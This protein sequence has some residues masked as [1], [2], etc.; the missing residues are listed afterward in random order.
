MTKA[1]LKKIMKKYNIIECE[2]EDVIF[3]VENL[4]QF[5]ATETEKNE[6][7]AINSIAMLKDAAYEVWNLLEYIDD[8]MEE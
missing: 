6:P 5:K 2:L 3:F 1:E 4:L 7:Y 8:I